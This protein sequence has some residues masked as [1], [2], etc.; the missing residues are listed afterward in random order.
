MSISTTSSCGASAASS[1]RASAFSAR[2]S[3]PPAASVAKISNTDMSKQTDVDAS[4]PAY[5]AAE[6]VACAQRTIDTAVRC[7]IATP[8]GTPVEPEVKIT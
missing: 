2:I 5:S 7:S 6:N 3:F 8:F 1:G 4:S